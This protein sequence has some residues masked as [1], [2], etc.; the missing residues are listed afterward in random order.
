MFGVVPRVVWERSS[1]PD[2]FN[3]I[4]M[5][6][7]CL[8]VD[9]GREKIIIETGIGEKW[10]PD[11][12]QRFGISRERSFSDSLASIAGCTPDDI[13]IVINTHLHFDHAGGNTIAGTGGKIEPQFKNAR[14]LVSASELAAAENPTERDR[15]SY[16]RE[17]W[18]A[19]K[20]SGQL[21]PMPDVYSPVEGLAMQQVRGHSATMQT[22]RLDRGGRTLYGFADL[23]PTR[24]HL[25]YP[26]V[27]G[28]DLYPLETLAAKKRLIPQ[29]IEEGWICL[30]YHDPD[31]PLATVREV[32]GRLKTT[33]VA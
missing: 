24:A 30:F 23:I 1:P 27:M 16:R 14:Y 33:A 9:T 32:D 13:T 12:A 8:F 28:Y 29:A 17:N 2:E 4:R 7:N 11:E 21:G 31:V 26:W 22:L 25:P 19:L 6:M 15:A 5:N 10:S 20:H 18:D 3:R